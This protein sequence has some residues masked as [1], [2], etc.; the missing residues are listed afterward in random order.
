MDLLL[1]N[2]IAFGYEGDCDLTDSDGIVLASA[3][4]LL[5]ESMIA[6]DPADD[7]SSTIFEAAGYRIIQSTNFSINDIK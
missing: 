6:I 7:N 2:C 4:M 3:G 1:D 5:R